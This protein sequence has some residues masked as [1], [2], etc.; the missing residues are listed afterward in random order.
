MTAS[1]PC[2]ATPPRRSCAGLR[3]SRTAA[4][5]CPTNTPPQKLRRHRASRIHTTPDPVP[6]PLLAEEAE[7]VEPP[8]AARRDT[9]ASAQL[10]IE[11]AWLGRPAPHF[12]ALLR[13]PADS[14]QRFRE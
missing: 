14:Q 2:R 10:Q 4:F 3:A 12:P 9:P 13:Q 1:L 6:V 5:R 7:P 8:I 11:P